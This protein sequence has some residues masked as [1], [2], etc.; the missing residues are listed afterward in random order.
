[1]REG[2]HLGILLP[3]DMEF[4]SKDYNLSFSAT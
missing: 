1:M 4:N 2:K 3:E